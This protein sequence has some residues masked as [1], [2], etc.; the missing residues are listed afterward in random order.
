MQVLLLSGVRH[1]VVGD[2]DVRGISGGQRKRVNIGIELV[3]DPSLLFLDEPTSG[4][5]STSSKLVVA[6]LQRVRFGNTTNISRASPSSGTQST[7]R[8]W[9]G[10]SLHP[11]D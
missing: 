7:L 6:T 3:T 11:T 10:F 8:C 4:L 2:T 1:E 9:C 5:D